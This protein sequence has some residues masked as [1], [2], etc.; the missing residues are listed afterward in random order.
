MVRVH[1]VAMTNASGVN[2]LGSSELNLNVGRGST[3]KRG[4]KDSGIC[5]AKS[6]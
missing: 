1:N 6:S 2:L 3:G 5:S 4:V